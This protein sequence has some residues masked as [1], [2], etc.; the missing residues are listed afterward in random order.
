MS[1]KK[2]VLE[3][4]CYIRTLLVATAVMQFSIGGEFANLAQARE[5]VGHTRLIPTPQLPS[6]M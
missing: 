5:P 3:S 4:L 2:C 1:I 6:N